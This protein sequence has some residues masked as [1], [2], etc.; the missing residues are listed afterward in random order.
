MSLATRRRGWKHGATAINRA[1]ASRVAHAQE[2]EQEMRG[3][4]V[5]PTASL[6]CALVLGT[7]QRADP[8][9]CDYAE[10]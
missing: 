6:G 9:E 2:D 7:V 5:S 1:A 3:E 8:S 4:K 10:E